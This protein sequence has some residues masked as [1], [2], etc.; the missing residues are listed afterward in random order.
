MV[1][2][3]ASVSSTRELGAAVQPGMGGSG[4]ASCGLSVAFAA[5]CS[6]GSV[7]RSRSCY[8]ANR[9]AR[10]LT[11]FARWLCCCDNSMGYGSPGVIQPRNQRTKC[12]SFFQGM[13]QSCVNDVLCKRHVSKSGVVQRCGAI[14]LV[15][16]S[17]QRWQVCIMACR[18]KVLVPVQP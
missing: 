17:D 11:V 10:A 7:W 18:Q 4:V 2:L 9:V 12:V 3:S 8:T 5:T 1:C 6:V 15:V 14:W 16:P 13:H